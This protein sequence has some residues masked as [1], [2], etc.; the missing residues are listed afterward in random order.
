[1]NGNT[2][3]TFAGVCVLAAGLSCIHSWF[4]VAVKAVWLAAFYVEMRRVAA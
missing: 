3:L 1:M 4:P 2:S